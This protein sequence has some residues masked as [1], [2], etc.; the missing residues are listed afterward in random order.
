MSIF[1]KV[2]LQTVSCVECKYCT[3]KTQGCFQEAHV[4]LSDI[5]FDV[6]AVPTR[7]CLLHALTVEA[8]LTCV[9]AT[10]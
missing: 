3:G 4:L 6:P 8:D 10:V 5:A 2:L 7:V 1:L 9:H